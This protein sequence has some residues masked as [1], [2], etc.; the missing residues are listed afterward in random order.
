M[1][2][3]RKL[4]AGHEKNRSR[5]I[6]DRYAAANQTPTPVRPHPPHWFLAMPEVF[7]VAVGRFL[8]SRQLV[9]ETDAGLL[10]DPFR[11]TEIRE[12]AGSPA[13]AIV[14][15]VDVLPTANPA[16]ERAGFQGALQ[17]SSILGFYPEF[18][19]ALAWPVS[20]QVASGVILSSINLRRNASSAS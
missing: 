8:A 7:A 11:L 5:K 20:A 14:P 3:D 10:R 13:T 2:A 17:W 1:D 18:R 6:R 15:V 16:G 19:L 9:R 12:A 4:A